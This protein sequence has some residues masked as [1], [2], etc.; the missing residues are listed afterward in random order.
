MELT[1]F[2]NKHQITISKPILEASQAGLDLM[3]QSQDPHHNEYHIYHILDNLSYL[4]TNITG[5]KSKIKFDVLIPAIC[6][7]DVWIANHT[8]HNIFELIFH[9][10]VE[11]KK[12]A[13]VWSKYSRNLLPNK[14]V[15]Q[16]HYCIRKHS[17]FQLLPPFNLEAKILIDLDKL[18][19]WNIHRFLGNRKTLVS[20][21]EFFTRY[22]VRMYYLYSWYAGLYFRVLENKLDKLSSS[23]WSSI[24]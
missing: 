5:L 19:V 20:Q 8:A 12:S 18:E 23:L 7:H 4:L 16:I 24:K 2:L 13:N 3:S 6:W 17:S 9:Q 11:G 14:L 1:A 22:V 21:K 15:S 10:I